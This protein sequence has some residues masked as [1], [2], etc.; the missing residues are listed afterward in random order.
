AIV[1]IS[2]ASAT[3]FAGTNS[4]RETAFGIETKLW[5]NTALSGRYQLENG[6]NGTDSFAVIGLQ[7]RLPINKQLALDLAF[8]RGFHMAGTGAS[9]T[10]GAF[11]LSF[12]PNPDLRTA[13]RYELRQQIGG[14]AQ[15]FTVGAAGRINEGL[16]TMARFQWSHADYQGRTT[17]ALTGT[18]AVALRPVKTD[19]R[20]LL[21]SY[22][23]RA[24]TQSGQA[25]SDTMSER[26]DTVSMDGYWQPERRTELFGRFA[27]KFGG[28]SR[29]GLISTSALT[30]MAQLRAARRI[31]RSLDTAFEYR[32]MAQPTTGTRRTSTGVELGYWMFA[33]IRF[34]VG[35][36]FTTA[37]EPDG[38]LL[39]R[40]RGFYFTISTKLSNL[41]DLF[42]TASAGLAP[43]GQTAAPTDKPEQP[44]SK[45][46]NDQPQGGAPPQ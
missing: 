36:N 13:A 8:E 42:G 41:F 35:Y 43:T 5:R 34:G 33:D 4:R 9:F 16:T 20:G 18:A 27:L 24:F 3:G 10:G 32:F 44:Q 19:D 11:G 39:T 2:D 29:E 22:T 30:Y 38:I 15:L 45:T 6:A 7:N 23:H 14:L 46:Q 26:G 12:L 37:T 17:D 25:A 1:P 31:R 28:N 40:P 21:F